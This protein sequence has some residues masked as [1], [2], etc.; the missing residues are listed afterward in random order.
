MKGFV[1]NLTKLSDL[2]EI[3]HMNLQKLILYF[4]NFFIK[5]YSLFKSKK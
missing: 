5:S 1:I 2:V 4:F 3:S